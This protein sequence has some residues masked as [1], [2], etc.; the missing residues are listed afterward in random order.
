MKRRKRIGGVLR[1]LLF[2]V[3]LLALFFGIRKTAGRIF[4]DR[5]ETK[6]A[7]HIKRLSTCWS[8]TLFCALWK[9]NRRLWSRK[10]IS[11]A[12]YPHVIST[13]NPAISDLSDRFNNEVF[14]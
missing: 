9:V 5:A 6:A 10:R 4:S 12:S 7:G 11:G 2:I 1:L 8:A 13:K 3:I 14:L